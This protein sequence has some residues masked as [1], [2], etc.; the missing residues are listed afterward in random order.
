MKAIK[1]GMLMCLSLLSFTLFAQVKQ[2]DVE[3]F[4]KALYQDIQLLDVRTPEEFDEGHLEN[5]MLADWKNKEEFERRIEA[6]DKNIPVLVY[7]RSG[8]R[9][10][11]ASQFLESK[12]FEVV[13]LLGGINAWNEAE[14]KVEKVKEKAPVSAEA[15]QQM[16][17]SSEYVLVNYGASWCPP[18]V[19]MAPVLEALKEVRPQ[20]TV[21]DID[22]GSQRA[23]MNTHSIKEVPT[24][25]LY[26]D[27][28]EV[29]RKSG[30][31]E[32]SE[33]VQALP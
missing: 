9:S 28:Q 31:T 6:M 26:Q 30:V 13:E 24:Y 5:A 11:E 32:L 18:C 8:G 3:G 4:E 10:L 22:A 23:L 15:Y 1:I 27:G 33:F 19:K 2:V 25:V 21:V 14:K 17:Q 20:L 16:I 12:G 29:W 7:C